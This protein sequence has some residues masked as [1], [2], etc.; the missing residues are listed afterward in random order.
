MDF[1]F[2]VHV[3][4]KIGDSIPR[5]LGQNKG[6]DDSYCLGNGPLWRWGEGGR[7]SGRESLINGCRFLPRAEAVLLQTK[8]WISA[9][10]TEVRKDVL[11]G[12]RGFHLR[13]TVLWVLLRSGAREQEQG[14]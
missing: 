9:G 1:P 11:G 3:C 13:C 8:V 14:S 7:K 2:R 6:S 10:F 5:C 4:K 12:C